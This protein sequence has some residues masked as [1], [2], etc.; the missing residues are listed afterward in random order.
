MVYSIVLTIPLYAIGTIILLLVYQCIIRYWTFFSKNNVK[1]VRGIPFLGVHYKG[2]LGKEPFSDSFM[3]SYNFYPNE[4]VFGIYDIGGRPSY[5]LR[6]LELI[7]QVGIKD[8]DH[9]TNH[10]FHMTAKA[11]PIFG[12][13][14]FM[15]RDQRWRDMRSTLSPAFTG[16][17]MKLMF[18]LLA[19]VSQKFCTFL[20]NDL[21]DDKTLECDVLDIITRFTND[22]IASTAFGL[23]INSLKDKTNEFYMTGKSVSTIDGIRG[24]IFLAY[25]TIPKL[26]NFLRIKF[27]NE[28]DANY[29]RKIVHNTIK[30][31][32][33]NNIVRN[34]MINILMEVKK[35][36]LVDEQEEA[37]VGFATIRDKDA[38]VV[39]ASVNK[40][41]S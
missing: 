13:S 3:R 23:E 9:F 25:G 7:K 35:G 39:G 19:D 22:A 40:I 2:V 36:I 16:K 21:S 15:M 32:E 37:D 4:R 12:R 29:F 34:D 10:T 5:I 20:K 41:Q 27:I 31:R 6:D 11:E 14:L 1:F 17:K 33:Q 18:Q 24:L 8:F 30:Y 28:N 26:M 38:L